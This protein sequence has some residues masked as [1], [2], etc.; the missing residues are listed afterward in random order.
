MEPD[1]AKRVEAWEKSPYYLMLPALEDEEE[2]QES[3]IA[4][5]NALI[6]ALRAAEKRPDVAKL[7]RKCWPKDADVSVG[8]I[9]LISAVHNVRDWEKR[10]PLFLF[11]EAL[12]SAL[13]ETP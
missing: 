12:A 11:V 1:L 2:L 4:F 8:R 5:V 10:P 3:L 13:G 7:V 9:L 6:A